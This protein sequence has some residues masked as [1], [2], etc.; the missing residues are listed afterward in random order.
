MAG[1]SADVERFVR[2]HE[3]HGTLS[4]AGGEPT[5]GGYPLRASC[6]LEPGSIAG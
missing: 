3:P 5:A 6:S 4:Y 1:V 2:A